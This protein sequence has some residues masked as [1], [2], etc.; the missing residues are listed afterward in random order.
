M[1]VRGTGVARYAGRR[2]IRRVG[3]VAVAIA[4][5]G[6]VA[7]AATA[8]GPRAR[9]PGWRDQ[10]VRSQVI[11]AVARGYGAVITVLD[12]SSAAA[13]HAVPASRAVAVAVKDEAGSRAIGVSLARMNRRWSGPASRPNELVWIVEVNRPGG[14]WHRGLH[15]DYDIRVI[16]ARTGR[17][18]AGEEGYEPGLEPP[19][20]LG[21]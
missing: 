13:L 8:G 20:P 10:P 9:A 16:D 18:T 21:K 7:E 4:L 19:P 1:A 11:A 2:L 12:Q 5:I 6:S 3:L 14:I 17:L 15:M